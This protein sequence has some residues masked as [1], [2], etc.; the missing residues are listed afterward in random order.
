M[1][2]KVRKGDRVV[3][4]AGKDKGREGEGAQAAGG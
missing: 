4:L 1:A 3:V 2:A